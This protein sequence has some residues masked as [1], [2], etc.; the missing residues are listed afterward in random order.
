MYD[1]ALGRWHV[2]DNL[3]EEY[4]SLSPYNYSFNNP[5]RFVDPDGNSP[6]D[7]ILQ[8]ATSALATAAWN[9]TLAAAAYVGESMRNAMENIEVSLFAEAEINVSAGAQG[10]E[11]VKGVGIDVN[12]KS[13]ELGGI[14]A[15]TEDGVKVDHLFKDGEADYSHNISAGY[16]GGEGGVKHS[17]TIDKNGE[18][19]KKQTDVS[20][21]G[22]VPGLIYEIKY[23]KETNNKTQTTTH[24]LKQGVSTGFSKGKGIVVRGSGSAG[25]Q[26][27]YKKDENK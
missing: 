25:I 15:S 23:T 21:G 22:G 18:E 5:V 3:A 1:A 17:Y 14:S 4:I 2:V 12:A 19:T 9:I 11:K 20:A 10:A 16:E 7:E 8:K 27:I 6:F 13:V 24:T 26:L